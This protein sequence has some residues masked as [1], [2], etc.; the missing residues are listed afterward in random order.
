VAFRFLFW[1]GI[2][3][4]F[5]CSSVAFGIMGGKRSQ[6]LFFWCGGYIKKKIL[7][8]FFARVRGEDL[9]K[10]LLE[11]G[12]PSISSTVFCVEIVVAFSK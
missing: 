12:N 10:L 8:S 11:F 1:V 3:L 6:V 7:F 5:F 9:F 4:T 2:A